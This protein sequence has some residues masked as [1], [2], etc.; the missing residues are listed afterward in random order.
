MTKSAS[1]ILREK[2]AATRAAQKAPAGGGQEQP[3]DQ[4]PAPAAP[5]SKAAPV[6]VTPVRSTLDL[7][8]TSHHRLKDW[9]SMTA[10][11]IGQTRV[12][13]QDVLR[14]AVALVLDNPQVAALV[15][16]QIRADKER[17]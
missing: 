14:A 15:R 10:A 5:L 16:D 2:M 9:E 6:K 17:R 12:T 4:P 1:E 13:R 3:V 8:P 11:E 7:D